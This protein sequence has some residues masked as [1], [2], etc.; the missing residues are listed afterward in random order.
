M[1]KMNENR[2]ELIGT[3]SRASTNW[4]QLSTNWDILEPNIILSDLK[5]IYCT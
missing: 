4:D 3:K 2:H 5:I 1:S